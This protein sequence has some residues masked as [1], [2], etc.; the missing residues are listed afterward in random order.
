VYFLKQRVAAFIDE[1]RNRILLHEQ[2]CFPRSR[3]F[4]V[5][6]EK[7]TASSQRVRSRYGSVES[8][9]V[10]RDPFKVGTVPRGPLRLKNV[11]TLSHIQPLRNE[12][13]ERWSSTNEGFGGL[14]AH[15]V[16]RFCTYSI[17]WFS[18]FQY[19]RFY[20]TNIDFVLQQPPTYCKR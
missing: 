10:L 2:L 15:S 14:C 4:R 5:V 6:A 9:H 1:E 17:F 7:K 12:G 19:Y 20:F 3:Q 8:T 13:F 18:V 11:G 16:F